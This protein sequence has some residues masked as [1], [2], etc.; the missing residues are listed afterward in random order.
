MVNDEALVELS[1]RWYL[2]MSLVF[3]WFWTAAVS[4]VEL[5]GQSRNL[6]LAGGIA[7]ASVANVLVLSGA[8]LDVLLGLW[9]WLRPSRSVHCVCAC[10]G[11]SAAAS[12]SGLGAVAG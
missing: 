1:D 5:Q 6:L 4:V 9:L 7:D 2:R 12:R 8:A 11:T 3:V 10:V